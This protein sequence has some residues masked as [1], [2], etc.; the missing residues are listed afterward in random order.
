MNSEYWKDSQLMEINE[1]L[2]ICRAFIEGEFKVPCHLDRRIHD[3][4]FNPQQEA[5]AS[6]TLWSL[7]NT[8]T[9]VFNELE[10]IPQFKTTTKLASFLQGAGPVSA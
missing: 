3:L 7:S 5:F 6:P 1:R 10:P 9:S 4:Y 8:F 2:I